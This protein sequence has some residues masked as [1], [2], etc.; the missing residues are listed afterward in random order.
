MILL[1]S[2]V[3]FVDVSNMVRGVF[4]RRATS[5]CTQPMPM[6]AAV[7]FPG[8]YPYQK[9]RSVPERPASATPKLTEKAIML[10]DRVVEASPLLLSEELAEL[11]VSQRDGLVCAQLLH[12]IQITGRQ[13]ETRD[14]LL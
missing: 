10:T 8:P 11:R 5:S 2:S 3:P 9:F 6:A 12:R 14:V 1:L 13:I 7:G 4:V